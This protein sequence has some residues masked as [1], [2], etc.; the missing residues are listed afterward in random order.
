MPRD[1]LLTV[2]HPG[3]WAEACLRGFWL[4]MPIRGVEVLALTHLT[5]LHP[6]AEAVA[7]LAPISSLEPLMGRDGE[8]RWMPFLA[9]P[10]RLRH[11]V[12]LGDAQVLGPWLPAS[13]LEYR[14]LEIDRLL[15][16]ISL[17]AL[18]SEPEG[19]G[20][21]PARAPAA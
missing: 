13:P 18:I 15:V 8:V 2:H 10:R 6:G 9:A 1:L 5:V 17:A 20:H 16:A 19:K 7:E 3:A 12:P 21:R 11:P 4:P 14:L